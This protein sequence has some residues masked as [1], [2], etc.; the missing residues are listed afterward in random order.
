M[1]KLRHVRA[2]TRP[3]IP[4]HHLPYPQGRY[5]QRVEDKR[6]V[7]DGCCDSDPPGVLDVHVVAIDTVGS[8][9]PWQ[10]GTI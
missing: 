3:H 9:A 6:H 4:L 2:W 1:G 5:G 10:V 7:L 8:F